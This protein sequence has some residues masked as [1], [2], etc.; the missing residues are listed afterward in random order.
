MGRFEPNVAGI[1]E[2]LHGVGGPVYRH[3]EEFAQRVA[4]RARELAPVDHGRVDEG[5]LRDSIHVDLVEVTAAGLTVR[6]AA[7][8]VDRRN[9]FRYGL[10]AHEG[11]GAI[12]P[13][14][15]GGRL[16]FFWAR[17]NIAVSVTQ[18]GE[19]GGT[20]FLTDALVSVNESTEDGFQLEPGDDLHPIG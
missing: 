15:V 2:L 19:T 11:H 9:G 1:D 13:K 16:N 6:V 8:P 4:A 7:D 18:V 12:H 10:V 17:K 5:A 14:S 20:P 3:V